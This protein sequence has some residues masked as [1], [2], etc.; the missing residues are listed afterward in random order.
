MNTTIANLLH[1]HTGHF[2]IGGS[3]R[4]ALFNQD[5]YIR[6]SSATQITHKNN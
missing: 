6:F 2:D 1:F 4:R 5:Y 3:C